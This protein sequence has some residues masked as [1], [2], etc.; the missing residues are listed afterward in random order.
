MAMLR[1][2]KRSGFIAILAGAA[3]LVTVATCDEAPYGSGFSVRSTNDDL[4]EDVVE[5]LFDG[6]CDDDCD[7]D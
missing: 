1:L 2:L 5:F 4:L 3:P 7:D 6:D